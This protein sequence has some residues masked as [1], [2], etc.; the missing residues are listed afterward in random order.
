MKFI[1]HILTFSLSVLL[2]FNYTRD[3]YKLLWKRQMSNWISAWFLIDWLIFIHQM[4]TA[5]T[6]RYSTNR[7]ES[8]IFIQEF[9]H[10]FETS[11]WFDVRTVTAI[12]TYSW[13]TTD[14]RLSQ[15]TITG[16]LLLHSI[17]H[18]IFLQKDNCHISD[19]HIHDKGEKLS[20]PGQRV[21][22]QSLTR[23]GHSLVPD[24]RGIFTQVTDKGQQV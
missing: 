22:L 14:S 1:I 7:R 6:Q 8:D 24:Q 11:A 5:F 21:F 2:W 4:I 12:R 19:L 20:I 23:E 13:P 17:E 16:Q 10:N 9:C 3:I 18:V 15:R